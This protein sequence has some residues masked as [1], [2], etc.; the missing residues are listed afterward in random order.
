M[1]RIRAERSTRW[2]PPAANSVVLHFRTVDA[3]YTN[4]GTDTDLVGA[5][6]DFTARYRRFT[7]RSISPQALAQALVS[8]RRHLI[9]SSVL[10]RIIR[11]HAGHGP[12][13]LQEG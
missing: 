5:L 13:R 8:G 7:S 4:P 2:R 1:A 3:M 11:A 6:A 10:R 12:P 9:S